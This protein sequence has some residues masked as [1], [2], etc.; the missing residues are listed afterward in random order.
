M[1]QFNEGE[2]VEHEGK[3]GVV[4][5]V[6]T[7]ETEWI[8]GEGDDEE[9]HKLEGSEEN[10]IYI[11]AFED[12]TVPLTEGEITSSEW[13]DG[14]DPD[15]EEIE[16]E[17]PKAQLAPVYYSV[18]HPDDYEEFENALAEIRESEELQNIPGAK[19]PHVGFNKLPKGWDRSSVLKAWSTFKGKWRVCYPRMIR[20]FGPRM[21]KRWCAALKDEVL[22]TT[23]WRSRY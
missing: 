14:D 20:H 15:P 7:F 18:D 21:A 23:K 10:P 12:E 6:I 8:V 2:V 19:D 13:D 1:A 22:Q 17:L 5:G 9:E 11:C 3:T 16:D 4:A